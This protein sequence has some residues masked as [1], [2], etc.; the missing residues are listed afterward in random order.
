MTDP[1]KVKIIQDEARKMSE[2][3]YHMVQLKGGGKAINLD[4]NALQLLEAYYDG[5]I[6]DSQVRYRARAGLLQQA[7]NKISQAP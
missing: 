7:S 3:A 6:P 4:Q 2:D 5:T 1:Y